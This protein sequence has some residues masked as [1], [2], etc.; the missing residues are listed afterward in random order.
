MTDLAHQLVP[1]TASAAVPAALMPYQQRWI[2]D[3]ASLKVMEK[4]RRTGITWAEAADDVLIA[5][6]AKDAG[7]QNVYYLGTDKEMT[8]EYIQACAM[9]AKAFNY[10]ADLVEEGFWDEE[11]DDKHIKTYTIRFPAS[12]FRITALA[13]RPRKLRG[14]QGVLVGD[15][16]AFV[17]DLPEL[18]KAAIAFLIWGGKVRL[19]STH[20]GVDNPFNELVQEIRGGK[21]RGTVHRVTFRDAVA[22]GLFKRVCMR[23]GKPWT[24]EAEQAFIEEVYGTYGPASEEELDCVPRNSAGA[25]LSRAVIEQ[26]MDDGTP[27]LSLERPDSFA[28][29]P[30]Y[31][32]Q[33]DV[34]DWLEK[35][36]RPHLDRLALQETHIRASLFGQDFGRYVDLSVLVPQIEDRKTLGRRVP[37]A[38]ELRN[39]PFDQQR[40]VLF[41]VADRL[42]RLRAG[43]LDATGNGMYLAEVAMQRYGSQRISQVMINDK[44]YAENF[45]PLKADLEDGTLSGL[46]RNGD[47]M[48]DLRAVEVVKGVPKIPAKRSV[49]RDGGKRHGDAAVA[50]LLG[51]SIARVEAVVIEWTPAPRHSRGFDNVGDDDND[52][53]IPE[54]QAW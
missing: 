10:A 7:G 36:I 2:A 53:R 8:E 49:G 29:L 12:G 28:E 20:D 37:F 1:D 51:N 18:L 22:E 16:A 52:I 14:R 44:F 33:A 48:D 46:P 21:R 42:P 19:I 35:H 38:V 41:Y 6:T 32:R 5:A 50:L 9:W 23:L 3:T 39:I 26:R 17:D 54:P 34:Q 40:Q 27:V 25:Y 24:E 30:E 15:E 4:G 47:W 45:P 13:S 31:I 11:E 43:A